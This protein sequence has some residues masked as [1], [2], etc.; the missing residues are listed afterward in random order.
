MPEPKKAQKIAETTEIIGEGKFVRLFKRGPWE[1]AER[2]GSHGAVLIIATTREG[3]LILVR[4]WREAV[5]AYVWELP[6]GLCDVADEQSSLTASRELWEE[7]GFK[8][9]EAKVLY[10]APSSPG[11]ASEMI[12]FVRIKACQKAGQGGGIDGENITVVVKKPDE[13]AG[14]LEKARVDGDLVDARIYMALWVVGQEPVPAV[15]KKRRLG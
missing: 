10:K 4:Q 9:E 13:V 1:I 11:M 5:R 8:G 7:T 12:E 15:S 6:A 14:F 3:E 2:V